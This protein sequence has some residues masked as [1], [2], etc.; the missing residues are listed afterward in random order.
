MVH[1]DVK[2]SNILLASDGQPMLLDFHLASEVMLGGSQPPPRMGG[3]RGYMSPE[4]EAAAED[5]RESHT[6]RQD[7]DRRSDIYSLG[8]TLYESL[9]GRLPP[10]DKMSSRKYGAGTCPTGV[11]VWRTSSTSVSQPGR[12][13]GIAMRRSWPLICAAT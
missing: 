9:A 13:S 12:P 3:T 2:P 10:A 7:V 8:V 4:Q 6:L 5:V 11:E 1:L